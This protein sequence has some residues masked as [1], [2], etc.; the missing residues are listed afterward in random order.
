VACAA[1][2]GAIEEMRTHDLAARARAVEAIIRRRLEAIASDHPTIGDIRGRGAMMAIEL[3]KP[4][5]LEPD[6]ARASAVAAYCHQHG[7]VVLTCGT[8]GN[9]FRF[10][11]PLSI[12]DTLLEEAFDVVAEAFGATA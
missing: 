12:S 10:L 3:V 7:V 1:A 6:A 5:T 9:V 8:W 4:G 11:P 2:L